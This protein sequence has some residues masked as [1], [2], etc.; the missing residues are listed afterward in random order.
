MIGIVMEFQIQ[1]LQISG[2][3]CRLYLPSDY[4]EGTKH[5][6]TIYVN[7]EIPIEEILTE[8]VENGGQTDFLLLSVKPSSWNDDFTPWTAAAFRKGEEAPAG[9]ADDYLSCLVKEI[10]PYMDTCYRTKPEPEHTALSGY[11]LGGLTAVYALY[12]TDVFGSIAS[13][14][15]SLWF[16]GFCD[17]MEREKPLR[18]D[19]QVYLS[20][21]KKESRSKN[22]RMGM[23][24]ACTERASEILHRQLEA[25]D[26]HAE[27]MD[28]RTGEVY[29]EW[30]EG[31][32]FHDIEGRF[33]KA[34]I[35][36]TQNMRET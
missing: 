17:F 6:P 25:A 29:F 12:K 10:K 11:S 19:L 28:E 9:R 4:D 22:P 13:L 20:L 27:G 8:L 3:D 35:W 7:G 2:M 32:H 1:E 36:W 26:A 15:G 24:A 33:V 34:I 31:G 16:D 21:G 23:V 18:R 30:N 14:S 5:Y